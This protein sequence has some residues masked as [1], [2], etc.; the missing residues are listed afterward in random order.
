MAATADPRA[1]QS[2]VLISSWPVAPSLPSS[3][4]RRPKRTPFLV[5]LV[6]HERGLF[7]KSLEL[8][9]TCPRSH[10]TIK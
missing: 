9:K 3:K 4:S 2:A 8:I 6:K 1:K 10:K 7:R 5:A